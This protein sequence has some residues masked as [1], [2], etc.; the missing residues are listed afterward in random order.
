MTFDMADIEISY[1]TLRK[2]QQAEKSSPQLTQIHRE[3]YTDVRMFLDRLYKRLEEEKKPQKKMLIAEECQNIEKII[4]NISEQR[5]K[6]IVLAAVAK[7]RG[8]SPNIKPLLDE[9]KALFDV[10]YKDIVSFRKQLFSSEDQ[11]TEPSIGRK[12]ETSSSQSEQKGSKPKREEKGKNTHPILRIVEDIPSFVGTDNKT[13]TLYKADI[14]SLPED[15][16]KMLINRNVAI[17][18]NEST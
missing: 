6:K 11:Q 7:A 14:V 13:Y 8:G 3:F 17:Q 18:V 4:T 5:E 2:I 1:K 9:E 12:Q 10:L 15:L 16:A